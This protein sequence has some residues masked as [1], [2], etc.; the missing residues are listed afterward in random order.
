[1]FTAEKNHLKIYEFEFLLALLSKI[2]TENA[3]SS[4]IFMSGIL[5]KCVGSELSR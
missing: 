3:S 1:M 4:F 2:I 5:D